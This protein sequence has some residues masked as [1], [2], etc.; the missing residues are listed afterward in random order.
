LFLARP[1]V[2]S[3]ILGMWAWILAFVAASF[4][5]AEAG[6]VRAAE[7]GAYSSASFHVMG[8]IASSSM[9]WLSDKIGA[10]RILITLASVSA[11][12]SFFFGWLIGFPAFLVLAWVR[13][14]RLRRSG[15]H[16]FC[17]QR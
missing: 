10:R 3:Q 8:V 2:F 13:C 16:R 9:G 17:P 4:A 11:A 7:L 12:C 15:I 14:M 6:L 1:N 5:A